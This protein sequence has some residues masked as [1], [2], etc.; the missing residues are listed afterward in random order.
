[1]TTN[2]WPMIDV[3]RVK[4]L[5]DHRLR[6]R[7]SDGNEG[8]RDF[9]DIFAAGGPMVEPLKAPDYFARAFLE[10]GVPTWPNGFDLDPVNLYLRLRNAGALTKAAAE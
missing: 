2:D 6:V 9:S 1:M 10:M 4:A 7:F 8:V 3:L 5:D